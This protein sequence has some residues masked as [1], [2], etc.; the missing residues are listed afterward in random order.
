MSKRRGLIANQQFLHCLRGNNVA[1][2]KPRSMSKSHDP[3]ELSVWTLPEFREAFEAYLDKVY[4]EMEHSA[5]GMSPKQAMAIGL[6][7]SGLRRHTLIPNTHDLLIMCLPS[8]PKGTAKIDPSRGVKIGYIFYWCPAFKNPKLAG[9]DVPV[10]YDPD[11][12]SMAIAW[13]KDHWETCQSEY[14]DHFRGRTEKEIELI[15]QEITAQNKLTGKR[16]TINASLI[17]KHLS[18]THA[19]EKVLQQRLRDNETHPASRPSHP[20]AKPTRSELDAL[21]DSYWAS[22]KNKILGD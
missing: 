9:S 11:D 15:T 19:T 1:L 7:Q 10:R 12:K 17:A 8:T 20:A 3:R 14:A 13:L 5:L 18:S 21:E 2:Q 4:G 6:A 22:F 16:R